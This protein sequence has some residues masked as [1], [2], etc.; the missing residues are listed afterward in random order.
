M[1]IVSRR[2]N[3]TGEFR[4]ESTS[5]VFSPLRVKDGERRRRGSFIFPSLL[6]SVVRVGG[7]LTRA[8]PPRRRRSR[9]LEE[10]TGMLSRVRR[11]LCTGAHSS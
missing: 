7:H 3:F 9:C 2:D 11:W 5:L 4:L 10:A 8:P 6:R 1:Q